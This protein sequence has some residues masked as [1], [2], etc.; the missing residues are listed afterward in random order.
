MT[1]VFQKKS[2]IL[3]YFFGGIALPCLLLSYFALR[4]I[5]NDRA[6]FEQQTINENQKIAQHVIERIHHRLNTTEQLCSDLIATFPQKL[7]QEIID[8]LQTLKNKL[9]FIEEIFS[10][11]KTTG[12]IELPI[13]RLLFTLKN[14]FEA[15]NLPS[16][17]SSSTAFSEG[18][19]N[20]FQQQ[21]YEQAIINYQHAYSQVWD[22][23]TQAEFLNALARVQK[24]ARR[25]HD[26]LDSYQKLNREFGLMSNKSGIPLGLAAQIET[27]F[28]HL[29]QKDTLSGVQIYLNA[30]NQ[31]LHGSWQLERAQYNFWTQA[32]KDS[33]NKIFSHVAL[34]VP[35][36]SYQNT[37][38]RFQ[39]Q[40]RLLKIKTDRLLNFQN[41]AVQTV[42]EKISPVSN[43]NVRFSLSSHNQKYLLSLLTADRERVD[44]IPK[45]AGLLWNMD[46]IKDTLHA[47]LIKENL[48]KQNIVWQVVDED[49]QA[50]LK[51]SD[52]N[53]ENAKSQVK[54]SFINNFPD[55]TLEFYHK[56]PLL[57][58]QILASRRSSYFYI[59]VLIAGILV[60]GSILTI[61]SVSHELELAKMKSDFVSSISHELKSPLTSIRQLAEM[62]QRGRVPSD[63]RR[64]KYY[65]VI[66]E[67]SELL[68]LLINNVLDYARMGEGMKRFFFEP[69]AM[70]SFLKEILTTIQSR[71]SHDGFDFELKFDESAPAISVDRI[72][73]SQ[74][75]TNLLDNAIKYSDT[76]KK[77]I[78]SLFVEDNFLN[79]SVQ[80]FGIGMKKEEWGKIFDQFYRISDEFVRSKKGSGLGLT[81][82]KQIVAAH[83]GMVEVI[84]EPGKGSTFTIKLP[85][86][87]R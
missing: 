2:K 64:Q 29:I 12:Q 74:A 52:F 82:V 37:F 79:I 20:E 38:T 27:G 85:I 11:Q 50:I 41:E 30:F 31:L 39:G 59:F 28:I 32:L 6:L 56:N 8:S 70:G 49:N 83:H 1:V 61:R 73:I 24:K 80:D 75:I 57:I 71:V 4:G 3:I 68:S 63:E 16:Q 18:I 21:S 42:E 65:D 51:A 44:R 84:S 78:V 87:S 66:V 67:Q 36:S 62:L 35:F 48:T 54:T 45:I 22:R 15:S 76:I 53:D 72:A 13:A 55:W 33:L 43:E 23:Q 19:K 9:P 34:S 14:N 86:R 7:N 47:N 26:A 60:F 40:E 5:Q 69:T 77:V 25:F 58:E 17:F 10:Y 81:L 46:V